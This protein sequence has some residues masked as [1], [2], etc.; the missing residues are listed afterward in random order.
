MTTI[1]VGLCAKFDIFAILKLYFGKNRFLN[2]TII[3]DRNQSN[4]TFMQNIFK[5]LNTN[6]FSFIVTKTNVSVTRDSRCH[7]IL[8]I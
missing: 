6:K 3:I 1:K 5:V 2:R 4:K 8:I 7:S